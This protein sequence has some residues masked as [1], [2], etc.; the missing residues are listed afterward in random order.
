VTTPI[1]PYKP[2]DA[3]WITEWIVQLLK[4]PWRSPFVVVL[5]TPTT[6]KVAD[7]VLIALTRILQL[8]AGRQ[9]AAPRRKQETVNNEMSA[10]L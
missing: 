7:I 8:A 5:S 2:G 10:L 6:V 3:V 4:P 1:H 9:D